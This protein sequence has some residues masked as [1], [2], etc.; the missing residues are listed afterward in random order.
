MTKRKQVCVIG[1][2]VSGLA[3]AHAFQE[4]GHAVTVLER[5][6]ELGGVWAPHRSYPGIRTQSPKDLYRYTDA[7]MP[8]GY[9]EWPSGAQV[10][11]Y[12]ESYARE[13]ALLPL[14]RFNTSVTGLSRRDGGGW[15]VETGEGRTG[16]DFVTIASGVFSDRNELVHP[17]MDEFR[18]GGGQILHSSEYT[19]PALVRGRK[20]VILGFSKSATDVAVNAVQQGAASV[21]IV[22]LEPVW[23]VPYHFAGLINFK[24][25]LYCR[26]SEGMF[27]GWEMSWGEKLRH[28]LTKPL[29]WANWR[30][31]ESLLTLQFGLK[32]LGMRPKQPIENG[33]ACGLSLATEG[34]Y[35]MLKDG[36]IKAIQGT[37]AGYEPGT[38]I[39]S[40]GDRL[41]ADVALLAVGWKMGVPF[42][43]QEVRQKLVEPDGQYRLYRL[44]VNPDVPDLGFVGFNSSFATVLTSDM[45]ARWLVRYADGKL[46]HQPSGSEMNGWIDRHLEWRRTVRP[47]AKGYG[48]LC[49]APYHF[50]HLDDLLADMGAVQ[51]RRS[52][53][54]AEVCLPPDADAYRGYLSTVPAYGLET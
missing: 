27:P 53:P 45:A 43:P 5:S 50:R 31:L 10:H 13:K 42:L 30:A 33:I 47:A 49:S 12:L 32:K 25:I 38:V 4:Q 54:L 48:G 37:I 26:A 7:A 9:P 17:G 21:T 29:V 18:A 22:Y 41:P 36:R 3:A 16:Y 6:H 15:W 46:A 14:I 2:G 40:T 35:P 19:D 8:E 34:F 23:R 39:L 11:A 24:R 44:A 1:A 51:R 52:N 28:A 20:V